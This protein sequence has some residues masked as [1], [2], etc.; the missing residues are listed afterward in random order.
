MK[1]GRQLGPAPEMLSII[2]QH[3]EMADGTGY[4]RGLRLE[5]ITPLARI[6]SLVNFY[7]NLCNPVDYAQA[8]T[9]HEALSFI[10]ARLKNKF[11]VAILQVLIHAL[12]VYPPGSIVRLSNDAIAMVVSVNPHKTL[13]PWVLRYDAG[14]AREDA[15]MLNLE[16]EDDISISRAM[17]P[18]LLPTPVFA[19]LSPRKRITYFF[20]GGLP[21][22]GG[23]K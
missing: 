21:D 17:R 2:E 7:D 4:P 9:P 20:D 14:V 15:V 10:F 13:R 11:D 16:S 19:Y 1:I 6:V 23:Q 8:L 3:H 12:G 18:A 22:T 5:Q